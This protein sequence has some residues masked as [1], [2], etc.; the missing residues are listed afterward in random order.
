VLVH[1]DDDATLRKPGVKG[2]DANP[3][4][5]LPLLVRPNVWSLIWH[6]A[7]RGAAKPPPVLGAEVYTGGDVL[8]DVPGKPQAI[9]TPGHTP[10]HCALLFEEHG[11][12]FVGDA[13]CTWNLVTGS[14]GPQL[15]PLAFNFD[16]A[17]SLASLA[18]VEP[19]EAAVLLPGH[20]EPWREGPA[21]AVARA[22]GLAASA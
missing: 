13:M 4:N 15:M 3:R 17:Q 19:L 7:R 10:G 14:T 12:L 21:A 1:R 11:A 18:A 6:M 5:I 8:A 2:G 22:R 16:T 9:A 20:G